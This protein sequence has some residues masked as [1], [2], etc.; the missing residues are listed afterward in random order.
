MFD[1]ARWSMNGTTVQAVS[2]NLDSHAHLQLRMM[3]SRESHDTNGILGC[4]SLRQKMLH[5]ELTASATNTA[6]DQTGEVFTPE[7]IPNDKQKMFTDDRR[8]L[9]TDFE[10][11]SPLSM[12][13]TSFGT[14]K[15]I[16]GASHDVRLTIGTE[17]V[18][19]RKSVYT[20]RIPGAPIGQATV[21]GGDGTDTHL[22]LDGQQLSDTDN[23]A[24]G[25]VTKL[26]TG[27]GYV[28]GDVDTD[29]NYNSTDAGGKKLARA[30]MLAR[31]AAPVAAYDDSGNAELVCF[32]EEVYIM[33]YYALPV[34]GTVP[35][36]MS[37]QIPFDS[38]T[39]LT[40]NISSKSTTLQITVP[41]NTTRILMALRKAGTPALGDNREL[42]GA[43]G[44][45]LA[46]NGANAHCG[47]QSL[48]IGIGGINLP[49]P[50]YSTS[51]ESGNFIRMW[52]DWQS[53]LKGSIGNTAGAQNMS[54]FQE[55]P[56]A[57]FRVIGSRDSV[58][59]NLTVRY[60]L[61]NDPADNTELCVYCIGTNVLEA[62]YDD[63]ASFQPTSVSVQE[64]I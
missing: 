45:S 50:Q 7:V 47:W 32:P 41:V 8:G 29:F 22:K 26:K 43:L 28:V 21:L 40:E 38:V 4:D 46:K 19:L 1:A 15:F 20:Q 58:A 35:R 55:D 6:F 16:P 64:V 42:L 48:S 2:G 3:G 51:F 52:A 11:A 34:H 62:T 61:H 37:I 36:P 13:L 25:D 49:A 14:N 27:V 30:R 23:I 39:L 57:A 63:D 9:D 33:A 5:P 53:Y 60:S 24:T 18:N 10:L 44:G 12:C 17:G 31:C 56:I 54:E 59:Q